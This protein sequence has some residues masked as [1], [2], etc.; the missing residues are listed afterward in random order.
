[1]QYEGSRHLRGHFS[2]AEESIN[3]IQFSNCG[4]NPGGGGPPPS[5]GPPTS[6]GPSAEL[7]DPPEPDGTFPPVAAIFLLVARVESAAG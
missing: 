6:S 5:I 4:D 7:P 2:S 1:L 3:R